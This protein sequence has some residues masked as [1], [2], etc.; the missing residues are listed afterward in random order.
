MSDT[1]VGS[2]GSLN[3]V[4]SDFSIHSKKLSTPQNDNYGLDPQ[5][6]KITAGS[7]K[8]S[9]NQFLD[10]VFCHADARDRVEALIAAN[11]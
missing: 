9:L 2:G 1:L 10:L 6:R 8:T 3:F 4:A 11:I 7:F 5:S